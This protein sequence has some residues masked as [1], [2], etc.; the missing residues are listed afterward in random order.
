MHLERRHVFKP[1]ILLLLIIT[2]L[3]I[4]MVIIMLNMKPL[5]GFSEL[6]GNEN[7]DDLCLSVYYVKPYL[8]TPYPWGVDNLVNA[9]YTNKIIISESDLEE[10]FDLIKQLS[11]DDLKPVKKKSFLN[12]RLYYVLESK[13]NG[14]LFDV[15]MW[16]GDSKNNSIFVNGYEVVG[17]DIFYDVIMPYL[18]ADMAEEYEKWKTEGKK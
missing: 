17:K 7:V 8:L 9:S 1:I 18:P 13:K 6:I 11:N 12:A 5:I 10:H 14:K 3:S 16:G 15:A 2:S 4:C